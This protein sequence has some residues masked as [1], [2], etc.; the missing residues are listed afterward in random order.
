VTSRPSHVARSAISRHTAAVIAFVNRRPRGSRDDE[1]AR[2]PVSRRVELADEP[3]VVEHR[4]REI[5]PPPLLL[6]LVHLEDVL[7]AEELLGADPV[8]DEPVKRRQQCRATRERQPGVCR[9]D[10]PRALEAVDDGLLAGGAGVRLLTRMDRARGP[11]DAQRLEAALLAK[12][13]RRLEIHRRQV[14][15]VDAL[16]EV[17]VSL[18]ALAARDRDLAR[19]GEAFEHLRDVAVVGPARRRPRHGARVGDVSRKQRAG[20]LQAG[21]DVA[22]KGLVRLSHPA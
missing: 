1:R 16:G 12:A 10:P 18:A 3:V 9:V 2:L 6:G 17:P 19:P 22:A 11:G 15:W 14:G 8:V 5:A 7:E 13:A 21:Q 20:L 4:Q